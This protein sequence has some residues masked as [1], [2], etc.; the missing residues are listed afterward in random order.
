MSY[1]DWISYYLIACKLRVGGLDVY[2]EILAL[3]MSR[4][5]D[6][7]TDNSV[8]KDQLGEL[9]DKGFLKSLVRAIFKVS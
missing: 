5:P 3:E 4:F 2:T 1:T 7:G 6:L 8:L 9:S